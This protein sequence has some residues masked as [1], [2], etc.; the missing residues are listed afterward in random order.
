MHISIQWNRYITK[1]K[2][3]YGLEIC[4]IKTKEEIKLLAKEIDICKRANRN[5]WIERITNEIIRE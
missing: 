3:Q 5:S 2:I 4:S 1:N